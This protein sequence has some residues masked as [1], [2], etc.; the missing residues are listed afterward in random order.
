MLVEP[1]DH[2]L[3]RVNVRRVE[4]LVD[5]EDVPQEGDVLGKERTAECRRRVWVLRFTAVIPAPGL[6]QVDPVLAAKQIQKATAEVSAEVIQLM[7][8]VQGDGIFPTLPHI[9]QQ[10]FEQ[11]AF[12]LPGIAQDQG[13][14]IGLIRRPPVQVYDDIGAVLVPADEKAVRVRLA[15]VAYEKEVGR[16][17]G[18]EDPLR[19]GSQSVSA[20]RV[21]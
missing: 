8:R 1:L 5:P 11:I 4:S 9:A 15:G 7:L 3:Q 18:R 20:S 21:G 17:G 13:A 19:K 2:Q 14:A 6:Q 16:A 10:E 12:A